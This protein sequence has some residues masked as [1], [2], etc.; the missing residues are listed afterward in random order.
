M[1]DSESPG[2]PIVS[3]IEAF[4]VCVF[5]VEGYDYLL[6]QKAVNQGS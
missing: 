3:Q 5:V 2:A 1:V 6:P 4:I